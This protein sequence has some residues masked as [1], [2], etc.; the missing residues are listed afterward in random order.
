F[1]SLPFK[2]LHILAVSQ[3]IGNQPTSGSSNTTLGHIPKRR[4]IILQRHLS[5]LGE[6]G[7]HLRELLWANH[8]SRR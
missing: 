6:T 1:I 3:N 2:K 7:F 5:R 4:S 8:F